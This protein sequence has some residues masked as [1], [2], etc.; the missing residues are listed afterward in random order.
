ML[1]NSKEEWKSESA[2]CQVE[3]DS[4]IIAR[5]IRTTIK[6][7]IKKKKKELESLK[8]SAAEV[9]KLVDC[10]LSWNKS[11]VV[12]NIETTIK[13]YI[14]QLVIRRERFLSET[15]GHQSTWATVER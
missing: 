4:L 5:N 6:L 14:N 9:G 13:L 15:Q 3:L 7:L 1:V 8:A 12:Q 2:V 11:I 10:L